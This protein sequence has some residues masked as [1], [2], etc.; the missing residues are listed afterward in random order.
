MKTCF[1]IILFLTTTLMFS[2]T[3]T[4]STDTTRGQSE[5]NYSKVNNTVTFN[6]KTPELLQTAGAPKAFYTYFWEFG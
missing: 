1:S 5:I 2:Q 3:A 6:A 4:P